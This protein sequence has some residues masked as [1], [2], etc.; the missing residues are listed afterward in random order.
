MTEVLSSADPGDPGDPGDPADPADPRRALRAE[1]LLRT[2]ND[3]GVLGAADV[4]TAQRLGSLTG[5]RDDTVLLA[6][7][8]AVR[9]VARVGSV[10][11]DLST[12]PD[13][14]PGLPWPEPVAWREVVAAS[15][16]LT[17]QVLRWDLGLL[18]L[19]RYWQQ[20]VRLAADLRRRVAAPP[21][22]VDEDRLRAA[23][24][25][26]FP[27]PRHQEQRA[28]AD[29]TARTRTTVVTGGPGTGKTS[30]IAR[31]LAVLLDQAEGRPG[32]GPPRVALVA[33]TGKAAARVREAVL[34]A[35]ASLPDPDRARVGDPAT[36]TLHRLLGPRPDTRSRFRHHRGNRLPHD[37]VV[38]DEAS[39]VS[40][41]LMQRLV[42][43]LRDDA[44]L[45]LVGDPDQLPPVEAGAVLADVVTGY[46][47]T[48][49]SPVAR[50]VTTHRYGAAIGA[51]AEAVRAGDAEAALAALRGGA[52]EVELVEEGDPARVLRGRLLDTAVAVRESAVRGDAE[53][54]LDALGRHRLL[55]AHREGPYGIRH[56]N[57]L[58][59]RWLSETT[60]DPLWA[61]A[62]AG[63]P[64]LV[65]RNDHALGLFNGDTGVVVTG[66]DGPV[67]VFAGVDGPVRLAPSRLPDVQTLHAMTV[68]KSQGSQAAQVTVLL[69]PPESPLLTRELLYTA[70][71]R[72]QHRVTVVGTEETV[73][74]AV[75]RRVQRASGLRHRL[76]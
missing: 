58:V 56:W 74:A 63:R 4:H 18:Y 40:L 55:C 60:G 32:A 50:L 41:S 36:S 17:E 26:M 33:P 9:S 65:T 45:V 6:L 12:V 15:P 3:A 10:C 51:L 11:V 44:R 23:L 16:L 25:R 42:E 5:E 8:L 28:A 38:V 19:D 14:G 68:H 64:L 7:A 1:G 30:T 69:P 13:V 52:E 71:T 61:P 24:D 35:T 21:P 29:L 46:Q 70:I 31:V 73:R 54:A 59:E 53:G 22:A 67:A 48:P 66:D 20:E 72:A 39:M 62:Y 76:A 49:S 2:F 27:D 43:A 34:A 75:A 57:R 37:V 47:D